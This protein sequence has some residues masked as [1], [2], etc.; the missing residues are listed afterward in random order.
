MTRHFVT[1]LVAGFAGLLCGAAGAF[2]DGGEA[3][4][5]IQNGDGTV[6]TFCIAFTGDGI[7]GDRLLESAGVTV[8]NWGGL[9]CAIGADEGCF[10]PRSVSSCTCQCKGGADCTYWAFFTQKYGQG[11][12]YASIGYQGQKAK[13]GDLQGWK[14]GKGG[15]QSAPAPKAI[16]FEQVC[17]HAP[18]GATGGSTATALPAASFTAVGA[19]SAVA[20]QGGTVTAVAPGQSA[21][22]ASGSASV[23]AASPTPSAEIQRITMVPGGATLPAFHVALL[24]D[25][26]ETGPGFRLYAFGLVVLLLIAGVAAASA[27]RYRRDRQG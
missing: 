3:G 15:P 1:L 6:D 22:S 8:V 12:V 23:P 4:L 17:G 2:A 7:T 11:W 24:D 26:E 19:S 5:V 10:E 13:D 14:W 21:T 16:T 25:A 18:S 9:V 27:W 20:T